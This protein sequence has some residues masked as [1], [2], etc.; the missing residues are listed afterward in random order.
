MLTYYDE[1]NVSFGSEPACGAGRWISYLATCYASPNGRVRSRLCKNGNRAALLVNPTSQNCRY[2]VFSKWVTVNRP[3]KTR[4]S[5]VFTQPRSE[6]AGT[7]PQLCPRSY[8]RRSGS[9]SRARRRTPDQFGQGETTKRTAR[10]WPP[11]KKSQAP[12]LIG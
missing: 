9:G 7:S 3:L 4:G 10:C 6:A 11:A 2:G 5:R 1:L 8:L 12:C